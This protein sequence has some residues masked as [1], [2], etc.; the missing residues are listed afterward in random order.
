VLP[1]AATID[2]EQIHHRGGAMQQIEQ[3]AVVRLQAVA[4]GLLARRRLQEMRRQMRNQEAALAAVAFDGQGR[5]LDALNGL[6]QLRRPVAVPKGV[7]GVF[8]TDGVF[9]LQERR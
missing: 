9:Q 2:A 3:L 7:H 4:R 5:D 6:Q 1:S 8:P